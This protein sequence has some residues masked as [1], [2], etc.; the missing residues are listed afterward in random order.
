MRHNQR[1]QYVSACSPYSHFL[2]LFSVSNK[3]SYCGQG[4]FYPMISGELMWVDREILAL[5]NIRYRILSASDIY[6]AKISPETV[7]AIS[8]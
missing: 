4:L 1:P 3:V 6:T 2:V 7:F 8:G 5:L